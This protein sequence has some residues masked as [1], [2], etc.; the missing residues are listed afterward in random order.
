MN[1][2][3]TTQTT[4]ANAAKRAN[5][6]G[7]TIPDILV[8]SFLTARRAVERAKAAEKK[9]SDA[10]KEYMAGENVRKMETS[11]AKVVIYDVAYPGTFDREGLARDY[12]HIYAQYFTP[13]VGTHEAFKVTP[14]A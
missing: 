10:I 1:G 8:H 14:K 2:V 9:M 12:P 5:D 7:L 4:I 13:S 6:T 11:E 3:T